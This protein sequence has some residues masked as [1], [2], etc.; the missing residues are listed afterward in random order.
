MKTNNTSRGKGI[1][2]TSTGGKPTNQETLY[3]REE[4]DKLLGNGN[5]TRPNRTSPNGGLRN[6]KAGK[7]I[8]AGE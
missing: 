1:E 8:R 2:N 3:Y 6:G 7:R 4:I 5:R